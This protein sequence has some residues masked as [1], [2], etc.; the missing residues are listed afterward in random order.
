MPRVGV[1]WRALDAPEAAVEVR[2]GYFYESSPVPEQTGRYNL[3]VTDRHVWSIG[4]GVALRGLRPLLEG[5]LHIDVHLTYALLPP[6]TMIKESPID[7]VGDLVAA[8][9]LYGG[10]LTMGVVFE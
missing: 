1:E 3:I 5:E 7:P 8:G 6:R 9:H 10:G 4:A 2:A